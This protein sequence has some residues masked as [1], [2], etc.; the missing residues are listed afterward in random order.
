LIA[1]NRDISKNSFTNKTL[2]I[3]LTELKKAELIQNGGNQYSFIKKFS[4]TSF[5]RLKN[6]V[7]P[8]RVITTANQN[9][10]HFEALIDLRNHIINTFVQF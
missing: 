8:E 5:W 10:R 3:T 4:N 9:Q 6:E 7:L 2:R 1:Q